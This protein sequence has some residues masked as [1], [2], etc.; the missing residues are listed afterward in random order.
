MKKYIVTLAA[1]AIAIGGAINLSGCG[2]G[3]EEDPNAL[4]ADGDETTSTN[5]PSQAELDALAKKKGYTNAPTT[6]K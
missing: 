1:M 4:G 3:P 5:E 2:G 6:T